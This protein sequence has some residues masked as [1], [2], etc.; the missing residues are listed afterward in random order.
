[1]TDYRK[2][3]ETHTVKELR[4]IAQS[5]RIRKWYV[6]SKRELID[7]ITPDEFLVAFFCSKLD[8]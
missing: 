8:P 2:N 1:M 5:L 3:L 4:A 6:L 7:A